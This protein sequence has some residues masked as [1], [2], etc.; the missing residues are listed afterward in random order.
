[1][2][3]YKL[4]SLNCFC[5]VPQILDNYISI[6]SVSRYF[7]ISSLISTVT[8]CVCL[9]IYCLTYIC[10]LEKAIMV[11]CIFFSPSYRW[12]LVSYH[13]G[14]KSCLM[15]SVFLNYWFLLL[16]WFSIW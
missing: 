9:V 13:C 6:F 10:L 4:P 5:Y 15:I 12:F 7:K 16:F 3:H 8:N 2:Y 1:L 14:W 11:S